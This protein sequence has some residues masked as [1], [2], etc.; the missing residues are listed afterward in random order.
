[1][2]QTKHLARVSAR[3]TD[4][5]RLW[6]IGA[7][8]IVSLLVTVYAVSGQPII[9][10]V[11]YL[12]PHL[13]I[14][15]I[16]LVSLWYPH[17][18]LQVTILL[19]AAVGLLTGWLFFSGHTLDP[20]LA[21]LN[22][23][24]DIWVVSALALL[25]RCRR[26]ESVPRSGDAADRGQPH[27]KPPVSDEIG[28]CIEALRLKDAR[29]REE[30]VRTL[31]G[32]R[33]PRVIDP[34]I[35]ALRDEDPAV[36]E[37]AARSLGKVGG[38]RA[39]H[40]LIEAMKDE[41][42]SMR[43]SAVQALAG[44]GEAAVEP[45]LRSL[46]DADWHVRMGAAIALRI[47]GEPAAIGPLIPALRDENRFVRREAAKSLGRFGDARAVPAL[48]QALHDADG[49]VRAKAEAALRRIREGNEGP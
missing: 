32:K 42:R 20:V 3:E 49:G 31:G 17:R 14:I 28:W 35:R 24:I 11:Y 39:I 34:L 8:A 21:V 22:A 4:I 13:Y 29:M 41:R 44:M 15:P 18:G 2:E 43:E 9:P 48:E 1:M 26:Q 40:A 23:G 46:G 12:L 45:M 37:E 6:L 25:A 38:E 30:A 10:Q 47:I 36:R 7:F 19:V 16:I 33:D 5:V 27:Q